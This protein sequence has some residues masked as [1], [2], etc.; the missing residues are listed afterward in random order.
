M[1]L[2]SRLGKRLINAAGRRMG[3]RNAYGTMR[4][5]MRSRGHEKATVAGMTEEEQL[6]QKI[7]DQAYGE[8]GK[9]ENL[10]GWEV[11]PELSDKRVVTYHNKTNNRTYIG[12]RG[13]DV[14]DKEREKFMGMGMAKDLYTDIFDPAGNIVRGSQGKN[15]LY[16]SDD[17]HFEKVRT[18]YGKNIS[19][20]GHSLGGSRAIRQSKRQNVYGQGFNVGRGFDK[21]Q[22]EDYKTCG[23]PNPP[24]WCTK[25]TSHHRSGDPLSLMNRFVHGK[26]KY[27][28]YN[29]KNNKNPHSL[30]QFEQGAGN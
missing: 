4:Q 21:G 27:Y 1:G 20:T 13:T 10:G 11:D 26:N 2:A 29:W 24:A 14:A 7:S 15:P 12:Y 16:Q 18:K 17:A 8:H 6:A 19:V 22:R 28:K 30:Q 3:M 5:G 25:F 9:R 23:K